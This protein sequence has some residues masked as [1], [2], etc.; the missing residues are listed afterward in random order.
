MIVFFY[1]LCYDKFIRVDG[2]CHLGVLGVMYLYSVSFLIYLAV[3][4]MI[5]YFVN[6]YILERKVIL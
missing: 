2:S 6:V 5:Q 4:A 3:S 1:F